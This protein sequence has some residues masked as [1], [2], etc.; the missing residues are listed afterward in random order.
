MFSVVLF[1]LFGISQLAS[2]NFNR[3][4]FTI[5]RA[6]DTVQQTSGRKK[7][8]YARVER[9]S[10]RVERGVVLVHTKFVFGISKCIKLAY[11]CLHELISDDDFWFI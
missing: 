2:T 11:V 1:H 10:K 3:M 8:A 7:S 6:L 4:K 9:S 5:S